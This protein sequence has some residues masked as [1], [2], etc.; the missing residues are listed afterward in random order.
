[1]QWLSASVTSFQNTMNAWKA[2]LEA[3]PVITQLVVYSY[4]HNTKASVS[5][6]VARQ[7]I[8][9]QRRRTTV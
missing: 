2:K 7:Y 1:V 8:G 3:G 5:A 4:K 9:T 6:L